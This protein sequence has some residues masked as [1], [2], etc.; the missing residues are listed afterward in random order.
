[1]SV[2][3]TEDLTSAKPQFN[4]PRMLTG[5]DFHEDNGASHFITIQ[6]VVALVKMARRA[7]VN[8]DY[9]LGE[10]IDQGIQ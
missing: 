8:K 7:G 6:S 4:G 5:F 9:L 1:M 10:T 2:I 3:T